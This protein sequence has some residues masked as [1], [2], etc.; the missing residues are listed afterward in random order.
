MAY[1]QFFWKHETLNWPN[2]YETTIT[3]ARHCQYYK[4]SSTIIMLCVSA[5][6]IKWSHICL[7]SHMSC[8]IYTTT[9][10]TSIKFAFR[11]FTSK[12]C[13]T[14]LIL[15]SIYETQIKC[16]WFSH[17][18]K[19]ITKKTNCIIYILDLINTMR[20]SH[21]IW[22]FLLSNVADQSLHMTFLG[23]VMLQHTICCS[24]AMQTHNLCV[25]YVLNVVLSSQ[26]R[27]LTVFL[28]HPKG[29]CLCL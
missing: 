9:D 8:P 5:Q 11:E 24:G 15:V 27:D 22:C 26:K 19:I 16:Y 13:H 14:N 18:Q 4:L 29:K 28:S 17:K 23:H 6:C 20:T 7:S 10:Q 21:G 3:T 12:N 25:V 1:Y 2:P